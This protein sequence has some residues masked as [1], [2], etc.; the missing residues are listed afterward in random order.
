[1]QTS[2]TSK[3]DFSSSVEGFPSTPEEKAVQEMMVVAVGLCQR[4]SKENKEAPENAQLWFRLLDRFV[5][6]VRPF[7]QEEVAFVL[8]RVSSS[9][10]PQV[11][12]Q[13]S[14]SRHRTN[15]RDSLPPHLAKTK[16]TLNFLMREVLR[17]M[18][19]HVALP[20]ILDKIVNEHARSEFSE[21][22]DII[23]N[24][25]ETFQYERSILGLTNHVVQHDMYEATNALRKRRLKVTRW[26]G[27]VSRWLTSLLQP[28]APRG[29]KCRVCLQAFLDKP[30]GVLIYSCGHAFHRTCLARVQ[31]CPLCVTSKN[32]KQKTKSRTAAG[33][34]DEETRQRG[35]TMKQKAENARDEDGQQALLESMLARYRAHVKATGEPRVVGG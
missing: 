18:W 26:A 12:A 2:Y 11:V 9:F 14:R 23:Y 1:M 3:S 22:K 30:A 15:A 27:R 10:S 8:T 16:Q 4:N 24:M 17:H 34:K 25:L 31:V 19:S 6:P 33:G 13:P 35:K 32:N 20:A 7:S 21:F 28:F 29:G 5:T